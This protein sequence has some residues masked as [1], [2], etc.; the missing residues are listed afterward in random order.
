MLTNQKQ[1]REQFWAANPD[2]EFQAREAGIFS[3]S[4]NHHCAT[5]RCAFV[6]FVDS[7]A[8]S[9]EISEKL[10]NRVTL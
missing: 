3:K 7:L 4:Q 6:D 5:V 2:F 8:K 10:A 1:I 9:G